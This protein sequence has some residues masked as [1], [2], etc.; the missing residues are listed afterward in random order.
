[1]TYRNNIYPLKNKKTNIEYTKDSGW[2]CMIR[3]GQMMLSKIIIE[4]KISQIDFF[5]KSSNSEKKKNEYYLFLSEDDI[6]K[7]RQETLVLLMDHPININLLSFI[8]ASEV[9]G[10]IKNINDISTTS[11]IPPFSIV[12]V[13]MEGSKMSLEKQPG[14]WFSDNI[15]IQIFTRIQNKY[16]II[17][18]YE[19][20][21]FKEGYIDERTIINK[22]FSKIS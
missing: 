4:S 18:D 21:D 14:E 5:I 15:L 17:K 19:F 12:N 7:Y 3:A 11:V 13:F 16:N 22:C 8:N 10:Y 2:G 1:M 20:L 6:N 9:F